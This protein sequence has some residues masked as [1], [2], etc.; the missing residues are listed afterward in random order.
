MSRHL[1]ECLLC[2]S[3]LHGDKCRKCKECP[4]CKKLVR[5][6]IDG[7]W[8]KPVLCLECTRLPGPTLCIEL[9]K[10]SVSGPVRKLIS[11]FCKQKDPTVIT[12]LASDFPSLY[13]FQE[14]CPVA[15]RRNNGVPKALPRGFISQ[16]DPIV[17]GGFIFGDFEEE[18]LY[19]TPVKT[20]YVPNDLLSLQKIQELTDLEE[21]TLQECF[22]FPN[23]GELSRTNP[24]LRKLYLIR[25]GPI[26]TLPEQIQT[27][28]VENVKVPSTALAGLTELCDLRTFRALPSLEHL[29]PPRHE[30]RNLSFE[31]GPVTPETASKSFAAFAMGSLVGQFLNW[32]DIEN[33]RLAN[34]TG[35]LLNP[36]ATIPRP[37][38]IDFTPFAARDDLAWMAQPTC[39]FDPAIPGLST[40][41]LGPDVEL[42]TDGVPD[43]GAL[44]RCSTS[45]NNL[46]L[47][48]DYEKAGPKQAYR[49]HGLNHLNV[50]LTMHTLDST[51]RI[52]WP[53]LSK[54]P[55]KTLVIGNHV[56][57]ENLPDSLRIPQAL[58]KLSLSLAP[59]VPD[60]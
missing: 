5:S 20:L 44:S 10:G 51:T 57:L 36:Q 56:I 31:V 43:R 60:E 14:L 1:P 42:V 23:L 47:M 25:C 9:S 32:L 59:M 28:W 49:L 58:Q 8:R 54:L 30:K 15:I 26:Y 12:G 19:A 4:T 22:K 7:D 13:H 37:L 21:L 48:G 6:N 39:R 2:R 35:A 50:L 29:L 18:L 52:S 46:A 38:R 11:E 24:K 40:L 45:L 53:E 33:V 3:P 16:T 41:V 34:K 27:L 17:N 55:I